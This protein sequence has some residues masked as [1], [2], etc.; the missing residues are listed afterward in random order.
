MKAVF[1]SLR[2]ENKTSALLVIQDEIGYQSEVVYVRA[3]FV[4]GLEEGDVLEI[5]EGYKVVDWKE[6]EL[7]NGKVVMLK[8]LGRH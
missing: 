3:S 4:A 6:A 1:N 2:G 7:A 5:P 8:T